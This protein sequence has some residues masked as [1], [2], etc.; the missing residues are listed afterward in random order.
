MADGLIFQAPDEVVHGT[1]AE[2]IEYLRR[3]TKN[4]VARGET[5]PPTAKG[6]RATEGPSPCAQAIPGRVE[7]YTLPDGREV[8][9][10]PLS[11]KDRSRLSARIP[12][13]LADDKLYR[14]PAPSERAAYEQE[15]SLEAFYRG[16]VWAVILCVYAG[17][18]KG[19]ARVFE[20]A[21]KET[22]YT[23]PDWSPV[24]A[25]IVEITERLAEQRQSALQVQ[26]GLLRGFFDAT[27][28]ALL[29]LLSQW[30][31][32]SRESCRA[33][34]EDLAH[35][36]SSTNAALRSGQS[37]WRTVL[38]ALQVV[39]SLPEDYRFSP[40]GTSEEAPESP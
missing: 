15:L 1:Q 18:E 13:W 28:H 21:D 12:A 20:P 7:P 4:G 14:Q 34:I 27:E 30:S 16:Q 25:E 31:T 29:T 3:L 37:N 33:W 19:A 8:W 9:V 17:P 32:D 5:P 24:V 10:R 11:M 2:Q 35:S 22:L 40:N 38:P 39:V 23:D 26:E 6:H 36:V